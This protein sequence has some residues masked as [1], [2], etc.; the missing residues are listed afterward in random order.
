M[1]YSDPRYSKRNVVATRVNDDLYE[2]LRD[3]ADRLGTQPA[4]LVHDIL[5]AAIR[6]SSE[7]GQGM[8]AIQI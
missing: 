7:Q 2:Q 1:A 6:R 3:T 4:T 5:E 8:R